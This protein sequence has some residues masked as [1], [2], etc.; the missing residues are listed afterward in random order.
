MTTMLDGGAK[1]YARELMLDVVQNP[2]TDCYLSDMLLKRVSFSVEL[3]SSMQ[4]NVQ[5]NAVP[6]FAPQSFEALK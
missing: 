2:G 6:P 1:R 4:M 3:S 5:L